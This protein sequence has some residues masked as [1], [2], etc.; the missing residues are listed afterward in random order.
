MLV[1][2][3]KI[4][5]TFVSTRRTLSPTKNPLLHRPF[6]A[7]LL[8]KWAVD[9]VK[10][11]G[12]FSRQLLSDPSAVY[13]LIP[14]LCPESSVLRQ[15][16]YRSEFAEVAITGI[17]NTSWN[18]NLARIDLPHGD[19]AWNIACAGRKVAILG[20]SG[21]IYIWDSVNFAEICTLQHNEPVTAFC[22]NSKATAVATYG[23]RHTKIWSVPSGQLQS[24][25]PNPEYVKAMTI[26]FAENDT[27]VFAASD[28][29][30]IRFLRTEDLKT[31]WQVADSNL[32]KE[33]SRIEGTVINSP[34]CMAFNG[35]GS[36]V[37][38]SYRGFPLSVW[39]LKGG[40]CI[41]R[42]KRVKSSKSIDAGPSA[43]WSAVNRFT[44]NP[45]S[46]HII[47]L[48]KGGY[49]FKWHPLTD[50]NHEAQFVADEIAASSD[51]KLF[52]TSNSDGTVR[53]WNFNYFTVIYQLSSADLVTGLAFSPDCTRFY[54]IRGSSISAWE[55]NALIRLSENDETFSDTASE[56][57]SATA[58]SYTSETNLTQYEAITSVAAAPGGIW[59][60]V[61]NEE[62]VV[63]LFNSQ[64][65]AGIELFRFFNFLGVNTITWSQ[66]AT[67]IAAS[68]LGGDILVKRFV[69]GS[70][71]TTE[72]KAL[73]TP[74]VDLEGRGIQQMVFNSGPS[75]LLIV[76]DDRG[77]IWSLENEAVVDELSFDHD[78]DRRWMQHPTESSMF[79]GIG[80]KDV[81]VFQWEGFREERCLFF[82]RVRP[83]PDGH[84]SLDCVT[85]QEPDAISK[86]GQNTVIDKA[87]VSQDKKHILVQIETVSSQGQSTKELLLFDVRSFAPG[88]ETDTMIEPLHFEYTASDVISKVEIPLGIISESRLVFLDQ[89][90]WLCTLKLKPT[91]DH[92]EALR[93]HYFIP[94]DWTSTEGI[95]QCAM[96]E[97]G[98]LLF[99]KEDKVAV[100][101]SDLNGSRF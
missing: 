59:Y 63:D 29:R 32:L 42:C 6:D 5:T 79:L 80:V 58:V 27:E 9:L 64:T 73:V 46:G 61:G 18:D 24:S 53:I 7:D 93:R 36:Q 1:K 56:G 99:P 33:T 66:D 54:D 92:D 40:Y 71:G 88:K 84:A 49:V 48:Y 13:K 96:M 81:R 11:V 91:Y 77:Q 94:R 45:V 44:W 16:F 69:P 67:H 87:M 83:L 89:E 75:L 95:G 41:G 35:D 82:P 50:D 90:L 39:E 57:Q 60:C 10:I 76:S 55:P 26:R 12:K 2:A 20:S 22:L 28:D 8:G 34:V 100:I 98:S 74:K 85:D 86:Y 62:G 97:D 68:D 25:T 51:G 43:S 19:Q 37:G 21:S 72:F 14:P 17:S 23:L 52:V 15:Q 30:V 65:E 38:V 47:G 78:I 101:R 31:G 70:N 3:A 4:L